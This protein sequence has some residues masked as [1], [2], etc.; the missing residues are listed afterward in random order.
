MTVEA[1]YDIASDHT[2]LH[3][4]SFPCFSLLFAYYLSVAVPSATPTVPPDYAFISKTIR[5]GKGWIWQH[6]ATFCGW[7]PN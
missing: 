1:L 2:D 7:W 4:F 6:A 5:Q 3:S